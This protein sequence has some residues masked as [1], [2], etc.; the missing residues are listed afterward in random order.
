MGLLKK[1]FNV[2]KKHLKKLHDRAIKIDALKDDIAK[3]SDD[4]LKN[5]T[6]EFQAKL[7]GIE[8]REEQKRST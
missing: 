8:N 6:K 5:K 2:N 1:I 7:A 4:E 3:L